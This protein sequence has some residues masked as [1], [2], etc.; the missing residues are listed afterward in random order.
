MADVPA[1]S[2][3]REQLPRDLEL[4]RELGLRLVATDQDWAWGKGEE[5]SGPSLPLLTG[6]MGRTPALRAL[7][8]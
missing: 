1:V 7:S 2:P 5:I 8:P 3:R 6:V 4:L